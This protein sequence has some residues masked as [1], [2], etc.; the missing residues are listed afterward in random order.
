MSQ[1]LVGGRIRLKQQRGWFAAGEGF[2]RA[3]VTL[4]D[5]AFKLFAWLCVR[6]DRSSGRIQITHRQISLEVGKSKRAVGTYVAE[7]QRKGIC[8][9]EA[10]TN[11]YARTWVEICD[12]Y[13]PYQKM[14]RW[15]EATGPIETAQ[16][17]L[18]ASPNSSDYVAMVRKW[19]VSLECGK[20]SFGAADERFALELEKR[21]VGLRT[22]ENALLLGS[23]RKYVAWLNRETDCAVSPISSL[24]YFEAV[25]AEVEEVKDTFTDDYRR[26]LRGKLKKFAGQLSHYTDTTGSQGTDSVAG[27]NK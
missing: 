21:G 8:R 9:V 10:A 18:G 15:L 12:E 6:A 3:L 1:V 22:V 4:S 24:R 26:Y 23:V 11:Q 5:G 20:R 2:Q 16:T 27:A 14:S 19:F 7:L 25:I 17:E 13:W